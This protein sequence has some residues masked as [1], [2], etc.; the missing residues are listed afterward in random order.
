M[1]ME[2]LIKAL[3]IAFI[4]ANLVALESEHENED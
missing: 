1:I 3:L 2:Y 4:Q